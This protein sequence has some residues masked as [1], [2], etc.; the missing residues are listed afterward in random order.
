VK[1]ILST[2]RI[3]QCG[4]CAAVPS[5]DIHHT[6]RHAGLAANIGEDHGSHRRKFG[7]LEDN[8]IAHR[9]GGCDFPSEHEKREIPRDNLP[10]DTPKAT[11]SDRAE[12]IN[13]AWP[14]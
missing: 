12:G 5:Y 4:A 6:R 14:A 9:Q 11:R 7:G 10:A 13:C 3:H 1:A 2:V 8:R